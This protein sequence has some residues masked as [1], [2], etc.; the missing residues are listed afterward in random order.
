MAAD[1]KKPQEQE[2][3]ESNDLDVGVEKKTL[4]G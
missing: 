3:D 1:N 2:L 4:D